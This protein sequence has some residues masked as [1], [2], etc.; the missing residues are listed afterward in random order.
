[1]DGVSR[2][3]T[4]FNPDWLRR[5]AAVPV[6]IETTAALLNELLRMKY[7]IDKTYYINDSGNICQILMDNLLADVA[8]DVLEAYQ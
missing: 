4:P 3:S 6:D 1:M 8:M 2:M 7:L 5:G